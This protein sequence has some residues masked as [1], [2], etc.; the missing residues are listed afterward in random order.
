MYRMVVTDL[1]GTLL[2]NKKQVSE[3][4]VKAIQNLKDQNITFVMAT[5]RSDVMTRAYTKQ[6]KNVDI[7]IGCDGA[8]IRNIR[9]GEILCE[10]HLRSETCHT[11]FEICKKYGLQYYVFA[12]DELVSDDPQNERFLIHQKFNQTVEEDEEISMQIVDDLNEYVNDH[13]IYKIVV[14]HNDT[15]YLD[16]VAEVIKK[17]TDADAIR[18]GKKVLAVKA[19]GVSKAEAI[20]KLAQK[21]GILIKDIIAFG[22]EVND[23]EM[24]T[25]VGLGI[26][27]ENADDVVK[28]A[29]DQI[30][31]SNDQD[32]VGKELEKIFGNAGK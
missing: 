24:L 7:V 32:G 13:I 21:L 14:S 19:R 3:A 27:M 15:S 8:V 16:K 4:N 18:S 28:E 30:A 23:I 12:K 22:D 10:N 1:D 11:T 20:K 17:E 6:L 26:A 5:G 2:N 29:A 31:G 9:T 25:L